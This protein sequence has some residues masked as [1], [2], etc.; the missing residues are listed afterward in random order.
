MS[1]I[2]KIFVTLIVLV[3]VIVAAAAIAVKV[4]DI[5]QYRDQIADALGKQ[6]GRTV[7]FGGKIELAFNTHGIGVAVEKASIGNPSW[8]SRPEMASIGNLELGVALMPLINRQLEVTELDVRDADIQLET[9][10]SDQHNWDLKPAAA[11]AEGKAP[12]APAKTATATPA[13]SSAAIGVRVNEL[14]IVNSKLAMRD[15]E[16]KVSTFKV[17]KMTLA[18]TGH[19]TNIALDADYNGAPIKLTLKAGAAD[20]MAAAKWPYDADVNYGDYHLHAQ[21]GADITGK[22]IE[23]NP[24][25]FKVG[26]TSLHGQMKANMSGAKTDLRGS[27]MGEKLDTADLKPP[28]GSSPNPPANASNA[29]AAAA[30]G[31]GPLFSTAPLDLSALK[32]AD[33]A[34]DVSIDEVVVGKNTLKQA[35]GKLA[36]AGGNLTLAPLKA[37]MG[38]SALEGEIKLTAAAAPAQYNLSFKAPGVDIANLLETI[39]TQAFM[40]GK[41]DA[42]IQLSGSGNSLHDMAST[43]QGHIDITAAG[44]QISSAA[45]G[46]VASSLAQILAPGA[47]NPTLNCVAIRFNVTGGVGKD[48]GILADSSASTVAGSGGFDL[49]KETVGLT[50]NAKAKLV[51]TRGLMPAVLIS[52]PLASPQIGINAV[53]E[54]QNVA[55]TFL[56]GNKIA[57]ALSGALGGSPSGEAA[58]PAI[59]TAPSGQNACVYSLEHKAA[60]PATAA[61]PASPN[62]S[63]K[64]VIGNPAGSAKDIG[65]QLKGLLGH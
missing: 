61:A 56:K 21:G 51:N 31:S 54:A 16:G 34:I 37:N 14:S 62:K 42:D 29:P 3:V 9:N 19:D 17:N 13:P 24:Y 27:I 11:A 49:G 41:G 1:V 36:L 4:V 18:P 25:E 47:A 6:I 39:G 38:T 44:G 15:K 48:N 57:S 65:N 43:T 63:I 8:A 46:G 20:L 23:L 40:S 58:V 7:K 12:A 33:A 10:A 53:G 22:S 28:S 35:S 50:L 26:S 59:Q 2:K 64:D 45:A 32:S 5:N 60:A 52:G 55:G 30:S